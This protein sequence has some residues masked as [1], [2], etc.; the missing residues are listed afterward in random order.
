MNNYTKSESQ[1]LSPKTFV[2]TDN[3]G[4]NYVKAFLKENAA[5]RLGVS[6]D[7]LKESNMIPDS[8]CVDEI[9]ENFDQISNTSTFTIQTRL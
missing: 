5:Q 8:V 3:R 1:R 6:V 7:D 2:F 9:V 4:G